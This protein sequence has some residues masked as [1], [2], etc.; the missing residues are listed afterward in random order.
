MILAFPPIEVKAAINAMGASERAKAILMKDLDPKEGRWECAYAVSFS[1]AIH[2]VISLG[3]SLDSMN[4]AAI[5]KSAKSLEALATES[6][7]AVKLFDWIRHEIS[8][9]T[10]ESVYGPKNPFKD[11]AIEAAFW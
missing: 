11:P 7:K 1:K 9:A 8:L 2:P 4:R 5:H 10:T 6:P 3:A